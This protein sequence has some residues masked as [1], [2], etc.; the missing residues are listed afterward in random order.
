MSAGTPPR[1]RATCSV[2][3]APWP[4]EGSPGGCPECGATS[5]DV[6]IGPAVEVDT[7]QPLRA[8]KAVQI[9]PAIEVD[10]ARPLYIEGISVAHPR[11]WKQRWDEILRDLA[12]LDAPR[13]NEPSRENILEAGRELGTFFVRA[14]ELRD[15]LSADPTPTVTKGQIQTAL[16]KDGNLALLADLANVIKHVKLDKP[17]W[18]GQA[19]SITRYSA[20]R[21]GSGESWWLKYEIVHGG[22]RDGL[23]VA[24]DSV[25][26]WRRQLSGWG[27]I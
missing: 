1:A 18:S 12:S 19:P 21:A 2:C 17:P 14:N 25:E 26:A 24:R 4:P 13:T 10:T 7:A 11:D 8:S 15:A 5:R 16:K 27:L 6:S 9:G 23:Q 20:L 3:G 22:L